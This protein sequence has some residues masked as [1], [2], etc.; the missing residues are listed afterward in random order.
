MIVSK[1]CVVLL[2]RLR[3]FAYYFFYEAK[4]SR[5]SSTYASIC[6]VTLKTYAL[7]STRGQGLT[8]P[9]IFCFLYGV[10]LATEE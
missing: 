1:V 8:S 7:F 9:N 10:F 2:V 5:R 6:P 3:L 4:I